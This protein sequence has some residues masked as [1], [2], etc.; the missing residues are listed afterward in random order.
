EG[1]ISI[2]LLYE[3]LPKEL[4]N[5]DDVP[6]IA[7][8]YHRYLVSYTVM[9]ALS[10]DEDYEAADVYKAEYERAREEIS[11]HKVP[12]SKDAD[13]VLELARAGILNAAEAAEW[14]NLPMK[15]KVWNRVEVE[16]K[17]L[18]LLRTGAI[19]K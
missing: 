3:R 7:E 5:D 13:R 12:I 6:E 19:S 14:L 10:K 11:S 1:Q 17:G 2:V 16:E 18:I 9:R 8:P 4:R 15:E